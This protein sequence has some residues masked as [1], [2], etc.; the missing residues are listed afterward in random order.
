MKDFKRDTTGSITIFLTLILVPC[1]VFISLFIDLA[2]FEYISYKLQA[3]SDLALNAGLTNYNSTLKEMYGL[4][5]V[6]EVEET[7]ELISEYFLSNLNVNYGLEASDNFDFYQ[8]K[9]PESD[10]QSIGSVV[11]NTN[12]RNPDVLKHQIVEYMKYLGPYE[13]GTEIFN[14]IDRIKNLENDNSALKQKNKIDKHLAQVDKEYQD[15]ANLVAKNS[16]FQ[17]YDYYGTLISYFM[18]LNESYKEK[19]QLEIDI[20]KLKKQ[21]EE[22]KAE[23]SKIESSTIQDDKQD[24]SLKDSE[25]KPSEEEDEEKTLIDDLNKKTEELSKLEKEI[26]NLNSNIRDTYTKCKKS[27][28]EQIKTETEIIKTTEK[29]EKKLKDAENAKKIL[30]TRYLNSTSDIVKDTLDKQL[31]E[32]N[33]ILGTTGGFNVEKLKDFAKENIVYLEEDKNYIKTLKEDLIK[34]FDK[35]GALS[36]ELTKDI[37]ADLGSYY[38]FYE[39][40]EETK[41]FIE[42]LKN[43]QVSGDKV[44]NELDNTKNKLE[45][46]YKDKL[47]GTL[48]IDD[49]EIPN[50]IYEQFNGQNSENQEVSSDSIEKDEFSNADDKLTFFGSGVLTGL[51]D[52]RDKLLTIQYAKGMFTNYRSNRDKDNQI[53]NSYTNIP[54]NKTNNYLYQGELE[55]LMHGKQS[56]KK[57][58]NKTVDFIKDIRFAFNYIYTFTDSQI[59]YELNTMSVGTVG[60]FGPLAVILFRE[61]LRI[62]IADLESQIDA[63]ELLNGQHVPLVKTSKEWNLKLANV[64]NLIIS[65]DSSADDDKNVLDLYYKD[66][67]NLLLLTTS[68]RML[69]ERIGDLIELNMTSN[70]NNGVVGESLSYELRNTYA[71]FQI[72]SELEADFIFMRLPFVNLFL[73]ESIKFEKRSMKYK[74]IKGY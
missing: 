70:K 51:E 33:N 64:F 74:D 3:S 56:T 73:D 25:E 49:V 27:F 1:V 7:E 42:F 26:E 69:Y 11:N 31:E 37:I 4:F 65:N 58:I 43:Y 32:Y 5:G 45:Q 15:L 8:I 21:I 60:T 23:K 6:S 14:Q 62:I 55:Y 52:L 71:Y 72:D 36:E 44:R 28:K 59:N 63:N 12:L 16:S 66:Y 48:D 67:T 9:L 47:S 35:Y 68:E 38:I 54:I 18:T 24:P 57:N 22:V 46:F 10:S 50:L 40:H 20:D 17:G 13:I 34:N 61:G 39:K 19:D 2:R 29:I 41:G 53:S 30:E